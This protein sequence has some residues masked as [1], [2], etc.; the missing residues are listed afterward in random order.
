MIPSE[1]MEI[2]D[3]LRL[4]AKAEYIRDLKVTDIQAGVIKAFN[5]MYGENQ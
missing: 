1:D 5:Q 3:L 2:E 4:T